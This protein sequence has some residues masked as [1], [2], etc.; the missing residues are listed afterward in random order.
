MKVNDLAAITFTDKAASELYAKIRTELTS[1]YAAT[2]DIALKNRINNLIKDLI[3]SNISTIHSFC[4]G[5]LKEYAVEGAGIDP[6][7]TLVDKRAAENLL[8]D[9]IDKVINDSLADPELNP[10]IKRVIRLFKGQTI[11]KEHRQK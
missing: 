11:L 10:V 1:L 9:S 8:N 6:G 7:F 4:S 2:E 5:I 3:N